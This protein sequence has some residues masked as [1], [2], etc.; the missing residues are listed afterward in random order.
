MNVANNDAE[1]GSEAHQ[2]YLAET[3]RLVD[4]EIESLFVLITSAVARAAGAASGGQQPTATRDART[5][6]VANGARVAVFTVEAITDLAEGV[7]RAQV[8]PTSQARCIM[9]LPDETTEQWELHRI[10]AGNAAPG[11]TWMYARTD[12]PVSEERIAQS[13]QPLFVQ[14]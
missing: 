6:R 14:Q 5:L 3:K 11:Y 12:T 2:E 7:D 13:L 1:Y 8:F 4:Q 10:G 9:T